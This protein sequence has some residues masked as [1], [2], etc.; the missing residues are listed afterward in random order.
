MEVTRALSEYVVNLKFSDLPKD[1]VEGAKLC[2]LD[3]LGVTLSG[4]KEPLVNI[5]AAVAEEQGGKH[6]A[7]LI[8]RKKRASLLQA[9]L[10]NGGA[11]HALDFDDVHLGMMGHPSAPVF[12]AILALGEWKKV[13]GEQFIAAFIAGFEAECRV[14]SIVY[15]EHYLCGWHA[16]G[17][18]GHFGA[19]AACANLIGLTPSQTVYALGIAG[20]Q[21]SGIKQVF[22][23][24]CKPFHAG[25][26]AMNGLLSALL[27]E[28]GFTSSIDM[29]EGSKGF[30]RV[31]ST[32]MDPPKALERLGEDYA[33]RGVVFKRHA[34]CF[35]THPAIDAVLALKGEQGLTADQVETIQLDAYT[36]ACDIAGIPAPQTGL[37]GKFSLAF[38]VALALGEGET[39]EPQFN[40]E[41]VRDPRLVALRDKVKIAPDPNLSPSRA[42]IRVA[43][44]DGR[45][46]EKF[47]ETLDLSKD[48]ERMKKHLVRKFQDLSTPIL[49]EE[50][51]KKLISRVKRL[52]KIAKLKALSN[53]I[54]G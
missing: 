30:S 3:W 49:G 43:T 38:C 10:I 40:D 12:P 18:L 23:T 13:S 32:R 35:E 44:R 39:G 51:T 20:T 21:A 8:G 9:A 29:L 33:I 7:T 45:V 42:K 36:V 16:T 34:S 22:G 25:K 17:T 27:A 37:E 5:L 4:S 28:K 50:K 6:Q 48:R 15:P 46:L 47:M 1:V 53:L 52:D 41:K 19:A 24:M 2:F 31:F 14:S 11:S 54:K 26:A